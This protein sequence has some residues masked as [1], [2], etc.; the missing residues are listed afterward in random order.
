MQCSHLYNIFNL[1]LGPALETWARFCDTTSGA[2]HQPQFSSN[3]VVDSRP[4]QAVFAKV[5]A[6][7]FQ[8]KSSKKFR[9]E[10]D[11]KKIIF[12]LSGSMNL[13]PM[14]KGYSNLLVVAVCEL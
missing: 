14:H 9:K 10:E 6:L 4:S 5:Q 3:F 11:G 8:P 1:W 12:F 13:F 7:G 2:E